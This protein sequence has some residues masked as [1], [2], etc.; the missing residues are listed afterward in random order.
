MLPAPIIA[1]SGIGGATGIAL[2]I[3]DLVITGGTSVSLG[4]ALT[5]SVFAAGI[6]W[7]LGKKLQRLE[8]G[9]SEAKDHYME[10]DRKLDKLPCR[11]T[12]DCATGLPK[13]HPK[14]P[15]DT[16]AY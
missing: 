6:V 13:I 3:G 2:I 12:A 7:Y 10:L 14:S 4:E 8:D 16:D 5:V 9:Q 15:P 1:A 11:R